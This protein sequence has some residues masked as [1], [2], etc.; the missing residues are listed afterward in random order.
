MLLQK[1]FCFQDTDIAPGSVATH[2][3]CGEIF[4]DIVILLLQNFLLIQTVKSL[5]IGQYLTD[6]CTIFVQKVP[7]FLVHPVY[8]ETCGGDEFY[9]QTLLC[10][11]DLSNHRIN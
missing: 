4:S 7:G 2:F 8:Y 5:K 11:T 6:I 3:R 10:H 1:S 9:V